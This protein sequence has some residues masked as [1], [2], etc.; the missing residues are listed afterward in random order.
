MELTVDFI[1]RFL[2]LERS[3]QELREREYEASSAIIERALVSVSEM[4]NT[5][6]TEIASLITAEADRATEAASIAVEA[7][8]EAEESAEAVEAD[9]ENEQTE[10][11]ASDDE[12]SAPPTE[13]EESHTKHAAPKSDSLPKRDHPLTRKVI[14]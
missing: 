2:R 4:L 10:S 13:S 5:F 14:G 1:E 12:T 3:V 8:V 11:E 6:R 7:S 9:G